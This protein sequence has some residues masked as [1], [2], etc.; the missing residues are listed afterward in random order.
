[1][2]RSS[3][4]GLTVD[5]DGLLPPTSTNHYPESN[6]STTYWSCN[7]TDRT[8]RFFE[9]P[10]TLAVQRVRSDDERYINWVKP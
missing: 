4:A 7:M 8:W 1:M 5:V 6:S 10:V 3:I 2:R 9:H